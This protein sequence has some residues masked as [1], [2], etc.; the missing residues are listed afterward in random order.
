MFG[1]KVNTPLAS[2]LNGPVLI[3]VTLVLAAVT[4]WPFRVSFVVTF[5]TVVAVV[6]PGV[7]TG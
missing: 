2:M 5:P 1:S 3:G 7:C 6:V 4:G